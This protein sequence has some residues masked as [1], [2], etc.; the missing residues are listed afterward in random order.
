LL[1]MK[2]EFYRAEDDVDKNVVATASWDGR[3]ATVASADA[4]LAGG[5]ERVFRKTPVVVHDPSLLPAGATGDVTLHPGD[6]VWFQAVA[7]VR[8]AHELDLVARVVSEVPEGGYDPASNYR[9]FEE[10][11]ERLSYPNRS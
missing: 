4:K 7:R 11:V 8:A 5:L 10:Q 2:I 6:T 9:S 1:V 3:D